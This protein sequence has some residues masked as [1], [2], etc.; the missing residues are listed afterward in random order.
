MDDKFKLDEEPYN[1][2]E[3]TDKV[4]REVK[5][6][7]DAFIFTSIK[8]FI[9]SISTYEIQKE[10]LV[11]AVLLIRMQHEAMEKYGTVL[12]NDYLTAVNMQMELERAYRKGFDDGVKHERRTVAE[13]WELFAKKFGINKENNEKSCS[14]C[15]LIDTCKDKID[16]RTIGDDIRY[17]MVVP[18]YI[19]GPNAECLVEDRSEEP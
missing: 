5:E 6:T 14:D 10:E 12:P 2:M 18:N 11:R 15:K 3:W 1:M 13:Q 17:G 9:D 16:V 19:P 8:P 4:I 7:E